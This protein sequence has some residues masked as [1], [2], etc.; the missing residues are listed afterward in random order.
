MANIEKKEV[1]RKHFKSEF[2][3]QVVGYI[4][5][6]FGLI[7]GLAWNEAIKS[8]ISYL[9]PLSQNSLLAQ[10]IYAI[11]ITVIV[12]LLTIYLTRFFIEEEK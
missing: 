3:K 1:Q 5:T 6:A 10:F 4:V 2:Q 8:L 9:F 11:S 12:V 7:A